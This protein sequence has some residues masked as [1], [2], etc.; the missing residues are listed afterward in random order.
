LEIALPDVLHDEHVVAS[1]LYFLPPM[2]R[3]T[4]DV[5]A[6]HVSPCC[7]M[8]AAAGTTSVRMKAQPHSEILRFG[9]VSPFLMKQILRNG[10]AEGSSLPQKP[11]RMP[12]F[13]LAI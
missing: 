12:A 13:D 7:G 2:V 10:I 6:P 9:M 1:Q 4:P 3:A 5:V 8:Y 11:V